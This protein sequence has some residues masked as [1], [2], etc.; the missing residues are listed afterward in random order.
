MLLYLSLHN[1]LHSLG[2]AVK[3]TIQQRYMSDEQRKMQPFV[4]CGRTTPFRYEVDPS[5]PQSEQRPI[6]KVDTNWPKQNKLLLLRNDGKFGHYGNQINSFLHAF[7]YARDHQL[8][9]GIL[10]HSWS[11][12]VMHTMF[13]E[14]NNFEEL[15]VQLRND[16]GIKV[17]RNPQHYQRYDEII[18]RNSQQLYFYKSANDTMDDWRETMEVH[19][20]ILRQLFL[21]YNR[22]HGYIHTGARAEDVCSTLNMFFH[23]KVGEAKYTASKCN[24]CM[25]L[26]LTGICI[27]FKFMLT[28]NQTTT[29]ILPSSCEAYRWECTM[30]S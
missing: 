22:G 23:D 11:M 7:D 20:S 26:L 13:Y 8:D 5:L 19:K 28:F 9:L 24:V 3:H 16:L 14:S 18:S 6:H 10:F 21:N 4:M 15:G 17:I 29:L 12:D 30:A 2:R 27:R 1:M 25:M